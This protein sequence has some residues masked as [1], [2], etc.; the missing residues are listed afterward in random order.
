MLAVYNRRTSHPCQVD[1]IPQ[2]QPYRFAGNQ[3]FFVLLMM[4]FSASLYDA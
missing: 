4:K 2:P 3:Y 1:G